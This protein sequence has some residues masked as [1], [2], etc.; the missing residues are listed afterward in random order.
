MENNTIITRPMRVEDAAAAMDLSAAEGWNQTANDWRFLTTHPGNICVAAVCEKEIIA[1]TTVIDYFGRL[2]WIGMVLV[3]KPYRRRGISKLLL[4]HVLEKLERFPSVKL[5]ATDQGEQVYKKFGFREEYHIARMVNPVSKNIAVPSAATG[6]RPIGL[7]HMPEIIALDEGVFGVN[8]APLLE[9]LIKSHPDKAWALHTDNHLTAFMLGRD[10]SKYHHI[11]P[12]IAQTQ[13]HAAMLLVH[14]L[15]KLA[16]P[17]VV[18]VL[19]DKKELMQALTAT[20]FSTQRYFTRMYKEKNPFP[21]N[22]GK[23]Y[24]ICGPEFG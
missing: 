13:S 4:D 20:G 7:D 10:G 24:A 17:V 3:K 21:G 12:L 1:T 5:D 11:G 19:C 6:V 2:A 23:L 22:N 18:D 15:S 14:A 8:R 9:M 16:G